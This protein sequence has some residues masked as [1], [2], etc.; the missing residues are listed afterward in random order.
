MSRW[1]TVDP[2]FAVSVS[3]ARHMGDTKD[4]EGVGLAPDVVTP[5]KDALRAAHLMA[6]RAL[7]TAA[8]DSSRRSSLDATIKDLE[9]ATPAR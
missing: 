9:Q 7:R 4:W 8:A 2:H 5:E 1:I 3:V 6:L